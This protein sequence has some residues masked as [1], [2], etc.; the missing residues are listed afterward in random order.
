MR[1]LNELRK[2]WQRATRYEFWPYWAFYAPVYPYGV[3][4]AWKARSLT[5]FTATNPIMRNSGVVQ[6]SKFDILR[7]IDPQYV[8][9]TIFFPANSS[10]DAIEASLRCSS[11]MYPFII[12]P[13]DGE[14]GNGVEKI[15]HY[16]EL[17]QYLRDHH[18]DMMVQQYISSDL[19][20]GVFYYRYPDEK[21]GH[22]NSVV[23]KGFLE[24]TGDGKSTLCRLIQ[25]HLRTKGRAE[26]LEQKFSARLDEV[27]PKGETL[28]LEPI[29]NHSRGTA[30]LNGNH[31]INERLVEIFDKI[32][33][34]DGFYYGRFDIRVP[35]L[36]DLYAGNNIYV[37][38]LNGVSSEP[39]HIY[40]PQHSLRDAY[41]ELREHFRIVLKISE[42]NHAKGVPYRPFKDFMADLTA[43]YRDQPTSAMPQEDPSLFVIQQG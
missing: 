11:I 20:L 28:Q 38:E 27:L 14:R 22:I 12:K 18:A 31:L 33:D 15:H 4:C 21:K 13:D 24:V 32:A 10:L 42:L 6:C 3:Y 39:G 19:E 41:K 40:D 37:M 16:T 7:R 34:I 29:A 30:F 26:Y 2:T 5:Y 8:P 36:D 23:I 35:N 9:E 17:Q 43:H 25:K 1:L